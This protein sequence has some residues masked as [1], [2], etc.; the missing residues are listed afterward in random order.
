MPTY[1]YIAI[2]GRGIRVSGAIEASDPDEAVSRLTE[3]GLRIESVQRTAATDSDAGGEDD[4]GRGLAPGE[5]RE[6]S[7]HIAGIISAG[8]PLEAGLAAV[9][10]EFPRGR[11]RRSLQNVIRELESGRDLESV[12]AAGRTPAYLSALVRAGR[13]TGRTG[14]ILESFVA[15]AAIVSDLRQTLW[16]AL[17]YPLVLLLVIVPLALF[18]QLWIVPAFAAI[19]DGFEIRLPLMTEA[20][21][22][23]SQFISEYG[24]KALACVAGAILALYLILRLALGP[25]GMRRTIGALPVIGPLLRWLAMARF[26]PLLS[27]LIE[28]RVP[29]DEALILAGEAVGDAEIGA[30]CRQLAAQ[31]Q[32]GESLESAALRTGRFPSSFVRALSWEGRRDGFPEVLQSMADMYAGRARALVLVLAAVLPPLAVLLV[33]VM[34]GFVVIALFMPLVELLNK[35]S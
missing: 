31:V 21:I 9:A 7:G 29:L 25:V 14:E 8:L 12:L 3:Q 11:L 6:I 20:L 5:A 23:L 33:A 26:S 27:L 4:R 35:L 13:R 28:S 24:W 17:A 10:E 16:M 1:T 22:G 34:V 30:D 15:N 18:L 2:D 19:F 32:A